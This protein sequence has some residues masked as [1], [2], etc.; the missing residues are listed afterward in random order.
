MSEISGEASIFFL[1]FCS[2]SYTSNLVFFSSKNFSELCKMQVVYDVCMDMLYT[3]IC[4]IC[5][6]PVHYM[7]YGQQTILTFHE[8]ITALYS[9]MFC[10]RVS[11]LKGARSQ[12]RPTMTNVGL[13]SFE[14]AVPP[15]SYVHV[16][17]ILLLRLILKLYCVKNIQCNS[18]ASL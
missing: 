11:S 5:L 9:C 4:T 18:V 1:G 13:H 12:G 16:Y 15:H 7:H 14:L 10:S 6:W 17:K 3:Y 2:V 8:T